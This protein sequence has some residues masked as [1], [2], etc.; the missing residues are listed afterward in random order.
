MN[1]LG[2]FLALA[3]AHFVPVLECGPQRAHGLLRLLLGERAQEHQH[4]ALLQEGQTLNRGEKERVTRFDRLHHLSHL[5]DF[6]DHDI[7]G[8][9]LRESWD[10]VGSRQAIKRTLTGLGKRSP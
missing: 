8:A 4:K 3:H 2:D 10:P 9:E 5:F 7:W 6:L 1:R